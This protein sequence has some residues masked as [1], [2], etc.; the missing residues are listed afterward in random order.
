[1][2][3]S[4]DS[5]FCTAEVQAA[6]VAWLQEARDLS[7]HTVR[8]YKSDSQFL[9][10]SLGSESPLAR[11]DQGLILEFFE[12]QRAAGL[13]SSSLRRRSSGVRSFCDFLERRG[14]LDASPWPAEGLA[15]RRTRALPRALS[16]DDLDRLVRYLVRKAGLSENGIEGIAAERASEVTTLI[17]TTLL[18]S[19]GLR[20]AE[21]VSFREHDID[22]TSRTIRVMGKGRRERVVYLANDWI[23]GL[24]ASYITLRAEIGISH[25]QFF[26]NA[27]RRPLSTS[28]VRT[29]LAGAAESAGVSRRVTP[30]MLR[31]SAATQLIESGVDIRFVQ[32]LLG[33]ASLATTE[34]Y[35]HVTDRALRNA[36]MSADVLKG[37]INPR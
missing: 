30:H 23:T 35:T 37:H 26:F 15:F 31:H 9:I 4:A 28:S 13:G 32:R 21:L 33:H 5:T 17:A 11:L 18:I 8:A 25:D 27:A 14:Y 29:R 16:A 12:K 36:V 19:T 22:L 2:K 20:V 7:P 3:T 6:F 1:M 34:I 10:R 24:V